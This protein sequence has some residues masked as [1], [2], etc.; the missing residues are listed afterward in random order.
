MVPSENFRKFFTE[1]VYQNSGTYFFQEITLI[2]LPRMGG[3]V[4]TTSQSLDDFYDGVG[5]S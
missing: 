4:A 5:N 1:A 3:K 2:L